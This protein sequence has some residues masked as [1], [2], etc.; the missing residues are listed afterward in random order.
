M[1]RTTETD[2]APLSPGLEAEVM[3]KVRRFPSSRRISISWQ[4]ESGSSPPEV[5]IIFFKHPN[6]VVGPFDDVLIP[7]GSTKTDWEVELGVVMGRL[8]KRVTIDEALDYIGGYLVVND[9]SERAAQLERGGQW[10]KGKSY[11]TFGPIGPWLVTREEVPDSGSLDLWLSVNGECRQNGNTGNMIFDVA[12]LISYISRFMT[13]MPGDIISTG[14]PAGVGLGLKPPRYL[15]GG[16]VMEL[17][18]ESLGVQR[19]HVVA[20]TSES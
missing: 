6:T 14:T 7:P 12:A 8:A 18:I 9:P 5:P 13:L 10:G 15:Q 3:L 20:E 19:H 16:D 11:D 1:S 17:G 4:R 2:S